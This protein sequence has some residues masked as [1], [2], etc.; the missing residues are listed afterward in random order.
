MEKKKRNFHRHLTTSGLN[1]YWII[2]AY[3]IIGWF[4]PVIGLIA[5]STEIATLLVID[6]TE[7][8]VQQF[9]ERI[10]LAALIT[11]DIIMAT[12]KCSYQ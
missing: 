1:L 12:L 2:I 4:Y 6:L 8:E 3:I 5:L 7:N 11:I 9:P 10:L